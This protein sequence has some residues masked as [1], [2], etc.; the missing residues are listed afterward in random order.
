MALI[1]YLVW[2][3]TT[4][5][6]LGRGIYAV[7]GSESIAQ[8]SAIPVRSRVIWAYVLSSAFAALAGLF[9]WPG[10]VLEIQS[11]RMA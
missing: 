1:W 9:C 4:R 8:L 5:S 2:V 10:L 11:Q 6:K 7:G 3:F